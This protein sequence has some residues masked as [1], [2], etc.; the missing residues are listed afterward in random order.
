MSG[1][2]SLS[3]RTIATSY[4]GLLAAFLAQKGV[5]AEIVT[6][7]GAVE[8][9]PRRISPTPSATWS[10]GNTLTSNGLSEKDIIRKVRQLSYKTV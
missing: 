1:V 5:A 3:G 2:Q 7:E 6:M 4:R 9:A 10:T 8:V